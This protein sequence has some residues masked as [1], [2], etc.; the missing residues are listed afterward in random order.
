MIYKLLNSTKFIIVSKCERRLSRIHPILAVK[1]VLQAFV[2]YY[3]VLVAIEV[4]L[5]TIS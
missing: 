2:N 1:R 4:A 5:P 3:N